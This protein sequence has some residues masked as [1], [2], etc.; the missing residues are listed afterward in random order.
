MA[1]SYTKGHR[2]KS[3][4]SRTV[5]TRTR[6]PSPVG[7][8]GITGTAFSTNKKRKLEIPFYALSQRNVG[9]NMSA[10][11]KDI[12]SRHGATPATTK[13]SAIAENHYRQLHQCVRQLDWDGFGQYF[14]TK[15]CQKCKP[16]VILDILCKQETREDVDECYSRYTHS[17]WDRNPPDGRTLLHHA[18]RFRAPVT[19]LEEMVDAFYYAAAEISKKSKKS[20]ITRLDQNMLALTSFKGKETPL[21]V[22]INYS[23]NG[24]AACL[25]RIRLLLGQNHRASTIPHFSGL[26]ALLMED[27][28][29]N[30]PLYNA[31]RASHDLEVSQYLVRLD[32]EYS[33]GQS[34]LEKGNKFTLVEN[35]GE[36]D[37]SHGHEPIET[38]TTQQAMNAAMMGTPLETLFRR[39]LVR[40]TAGTKM[41]NDLLYMVMT[42]GKAIQKSS[43]F[44]GDLR[45]RTE[46]SLSS[47]GREHSG[48][49]TVNLERLL[50]ACIRCSAVF[51]SVKRAMAIV[52]YAAQSYP[53]QLNQ[54]EDNG[55]L[56]L[57]LALDLGKNVLPDLIVPSKVVRFLLQQNPSAASIPDPVSGCLPLLLALRRSPVQRKESM[58]AAL[59]DNGNELVG[60][61]VGQADP[62]HGAVDKSLKAADSDDDNL[63]CD[64]FSAHPVGAD[65]LVEE[66]VGFSNP[67]LYPFILAGMQSY[68]T[69]T[70]L[71]LKGC[72]IKDGLLLPQ[73]HR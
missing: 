4:P 60:C 45:L 72:S 56:P 62:V 73:G 64:I 1:D 48:A 35:D 6:T 8:G 59:L 10:L 44:G 20:H 26:V 46:A 65:D 33:G 15:C 9:L 28:D 49:P 27:A 71:L 16:E 19:L 58:L 37:Y 14:R 40:T 68:L 53:L 18:C 17:W 54:S 70:F 32:F 51:T 63:V 3:L 21:H 50:T 61:D 47:V 42:T 66:I 31:V 67:P 52:K 69:S 29:G 24:S 13:M 22:A 25:Q 5:S 43:Y 2:H 12:V 39:G 55:R 7:C 11:S 34:L 23:D 30:T 36:E 57:H 41:R 38:A